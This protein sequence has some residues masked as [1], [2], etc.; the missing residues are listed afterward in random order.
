MFEGM[1]MRSLG[2]IKNPQDH[3]DD[4]STTQKTE[5]DRHKDPVCNMTVS[6]DSEYWGRSVFEQALPA[7]GF[8]SICLARHR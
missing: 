6:N 5:K 7:D 4:M 2:K 8:A 1:L 3:D